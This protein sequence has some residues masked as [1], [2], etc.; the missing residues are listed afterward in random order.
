MN[1]LSL[2][3][4]RQCL[5][6]MVLALAKKCHCQGEGEFMIVL[7]MVK[8]TAW[9]N[10]SKIR[11]RVVQ[12]KIQKECTSLASRVELKV[13]ALVSLTRFLDICHIL[14][15]RWTDVIIVCCPALFAK[16]IFNVATIMCVNVLFYGKS[17]NT[18]IYF[19]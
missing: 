3:Y 14:C 8:S 12:V 1:G 9:D 15:N 4:H 18:M 19:F 17:R 13:G 5:M 10:F 16:F 11:L 6:I 7:S 2:N